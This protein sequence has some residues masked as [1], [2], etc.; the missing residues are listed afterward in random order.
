MTPRQRRKVELYMTDDDIL[1]DS[2]SLYDDDDLEGPDSADLLSLAELRE[3]YPE[4]A[5]WF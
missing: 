3:R 1:W 4:L 5:D 2:Y